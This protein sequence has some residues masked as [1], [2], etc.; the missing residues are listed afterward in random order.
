MFWD[1]WIYIHAIYLHKN[2]KESVCEAYDLQVGKGRSFYHAI[3]IQTLK[4]PKDL[5]VSFT[6]QMINVPILK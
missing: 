4:P 2:F 1:G 5:C 6:T 3:N